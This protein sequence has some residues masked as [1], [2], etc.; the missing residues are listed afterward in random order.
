[1]NLTID[2][3]NTRTKFG[4][5]E[6]EE[7]VH[8]KVVEQWTMDDLKALVNNQNVENII[9]ST[10]KTVNQ[11]MENYLK[12]QGYFLNLDADTPLPITNGYGTPKTLGK[13]RLAAVVGANTVFPNQHSLVIDA[14]TCTTYDII[15]ASGTYLGGNITPG[16]R[17]RYRAMQHFTSKLPLVTPMEDVKNGIGKNTTEA[18][19]VGGGLGNIL[20]M[21]A[22]IRYFERQFEGI[23]T[24]LTGGDAE[25]FAKRLKTKIFADANLVLIGLNKI[26]IHNVELL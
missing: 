20:E 7:L 26:L 2:I 11:P 12:G 5:F 25:Y 15:D 22:W 13:D 23:N 1:M 4:F 24:T 8:K 14:G 21:E 9:C 16:L 6:Q 3:G 17:M 10:V 19:Q 18:L